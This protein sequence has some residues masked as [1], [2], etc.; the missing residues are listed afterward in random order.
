MTTLQ[1]FSTISSEATFSA[2]R[3]RSETGY[4]ISFSLK[5]RLDNQ[6]VYLV[7]KGEIRELNALI[8]WFAKNDENTRVKHAGLHCG[9]G[10]PRR[11]HTVSRES[12]RTTCLPSRP[13][14]GSCA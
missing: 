7:P 9:M 8:D 5:H 2:F 1:V 14:D 11:G 4:A 13:K 10:N 3:E 12:F 6:T